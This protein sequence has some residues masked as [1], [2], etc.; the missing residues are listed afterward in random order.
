MT[1]GKQYVSSSKFHSET[2]K[3]QFYD[4]GWRK[5]SELW[6]CELYSVFALANTKINTNERT[7]KRINITRFFHLASLSRPSINRFIPVL[8]GCHFYFHRVF[9]ICTCIERRFYKNYGGRSCGGIFHPDARPFLA[10]ACRAA[11]SHAFGL[12]L[13]CCIVCRL[14]VKHFI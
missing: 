7:G 10:S 4:W 2:N 1:S 13:R 3:N 11:T 8:T 5:M 9:N 6:S 12:T 14:F